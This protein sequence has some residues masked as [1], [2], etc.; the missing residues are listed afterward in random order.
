M[1]RLAKYLVPYMGFLLLCVALLFGQANADLNLPNRMSDIIN[2]GIQQGGVEHVAPNVMSENAYKLTTHFMDDTEHALVDAHYTKTAADTTLYPK[3][4]GDLYVL[5][6]VTAQEQTSLN[7]AFSRSAWTLVQVLKNMGGGTNTAAAPDMQDMDI[8]KLYEV[9]PMLGMLPETTLN[10]AKASTESTDAMMLSQVGIVFTKGFYKE[11]GMDMGKMQSDYIIRIGLIMLLIAVL[12]G[13][14][15]VLVSLFSSRI[16]SGV[17]RDLRRDIFAKVES[18]TNAE[19]D[20]YSTA[21]LITRSTNDVTQVQMVL[22]IG[23][24]MLCYAP[25]MAI[26]GVI[27]AVDK[28]VS[29][30]WLIAVAVLLL[31]GLIL[32]VFSIALP[33]FKLIQTLVDKLNLVSRE[34]LTGMLVIRAFG[35]QKHEEERFDKTNLDVSNVNLF[36]NRVMVTMFPF[37]MLIMNGTML[38]V[39]WVGGHQIAES[40]MQIGDMMAFMQYAMQIIMSFLMISMMFIFIP[41]AAVSAARIADVLETKESVK[42]P[43]SPKSFDKTQTGVVEFRNVNFRYDGA[44]E[45][46]L[47][48]ISF[49]AKPGQTTAIIGSTGSGK[50]T[51]ANLILRFYDATAGEVLVSGVNVRDVR[52]HDLREK[53]GYVPQ[54]GELLSGTIESNLKYGQKQAS[55]ADVKLAAEIAQATA[56]I[57]EKTDGFAEAIAQGGTNVSGGQKQRLSIARALVKKPEVLI[58]DDSFS[59]LDFKTDVALRKALKEHTVHSA[60]IVVAQRVSTI[61]QAEQIIVLDEGRIVGKGTHKEL[62]ISCP[63]YLEIASSQLSQAELA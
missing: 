45:D 1:R 22:M 43:V 51:I 61:M 42:D 53:M 29:M 3:A 56:F 54:K 59:A 19:F 55:E 12:G 63:A 60:V 18:F 36:I 4:S 2:V 37:M 33:K 52:Q 28:S 8:T 26:G 5:D 10:E 9:L 46:A 39:I 15:T 47:Q 20:K 34:N 57:E 48:N 38:M 62:L 16:A 6:A 17:A 7:N 31:L 11:L 23:I 30:S 41:R 25:M 13:A 44:A 35:T 14:A 32:I 49:T 21:S 50:T 27:M 24:R 58:F 40:A